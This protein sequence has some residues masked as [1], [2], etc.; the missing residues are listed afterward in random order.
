MRAASLS[1][2]IRAVVFDFDGVIADTEGLHF[3]TLAAVLAEDGIRVRREEDEGRFLGITDAGCFALAFRDAG[4]EL[5]PGGCEALVARKAERY[6]RG[7]E[8]VRLFP[9]A[10]DLVEEAA[11]RLPVTIASC[12]R[13]EDIE[14]VLERHGLRRFFDRFVSADDIQRSK[15]DPEVFLKAVALARNQGI[16]LDGLTTVNIDFMRM[17]RPQTNV[18]TRPVAGNKGQGISLVGHHEVLIPLI[19][20]AVIENEVK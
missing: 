3:E 10:R 19:A 1:R 13:R 11:R 8:S 14:G 6:R 4:R 7:I 16:G 5:P 12:G 20:A 15:P 2:Q 18:V 9:G 17:Y